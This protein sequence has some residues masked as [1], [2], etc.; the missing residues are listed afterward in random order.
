MTTLYDLT[1]NMLQDEALLKAMAK[2]AAYFVIRDHPTLTG[3][4]AG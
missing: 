4:E 2:K 3:W 1:P